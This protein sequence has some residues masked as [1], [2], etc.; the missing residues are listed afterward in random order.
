M[1]DSALSNLTFLY[2]QKKITKKREMFEDA[3]LDGRT[4][5]NR[6]GQERSVRKLRVGAE[7]A[8]LDIREFIFVENR[9]YIFLTGN[10]LLR[11]KHTGV[12]SQ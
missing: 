5:A 4:P 2:I 6:K 11:T 12:V 10:E 1:Q 7:S 3:K 8:L 9:L